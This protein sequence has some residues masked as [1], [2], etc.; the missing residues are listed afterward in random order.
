MNALKMRPP[1]NVTFSQKLALVKSAFFM[2]DFL[3]LQM[4]NKKGT[5]TMIP[6]KLPQI[7][8]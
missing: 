5:A 4:E 3:K 8:M 1:A 6:N 7:A 2:S